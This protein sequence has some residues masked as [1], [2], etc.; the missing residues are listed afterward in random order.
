MYAFHFSDGDN[1]GDDVPKCIDLLTEQMLPKLNL[2]GYGQVESPYGSGEFFE[3]VNELVDE[4]ENV[5]VSRVPDREAILGQHQGV[6]EDGA[7]SGCHRASRPQRRRV[8]GR[9]EAIAGLLANPADGRILDSMRPG[10]RERCGSRSD[11]R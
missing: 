3:H 11:G 9:L 4:H 6:P 8:R 10:H 7:V 1:W 5:V 2:F